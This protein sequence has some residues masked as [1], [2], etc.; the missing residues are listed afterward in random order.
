MHPEDAYTN[1]YDYDVQSQFL[2]EPNR[3]LDA[4]H[5]RLVKE[6]PVYRVSDQSLEKA[7]W[8]LFVDSLD[9]LRDCSAALS[10]KEHR[11]AGRLFRDALET[12]D[13]AEFLATNDAK[14][15]KALTEWYENEVISHRKSRDALQR[16]LGQDVSQQRRQRYRE[17]SKFTHRTYRALLQSYSVGR[18]DR[19]VYDGLRD[20]QIL[21]LP[22]TIAAF[23]TILADRLIEF[24]SKIE[25][26]GILP[27]EVNREIWS[28]SLESHTVP[29]RFV[30]HQ[31]KAT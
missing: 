17:L 21:V 30:P 5:Q 19:L 8:M 16:K 23:L 3:I 6:G 28:Q 11:I 22:Q 25:A 24:S 2:R 27:D 7:L 4:Y 29:R 14:A 9:A 26:L 10:R 20:S 1:P 12:M 13:L 31:W 15:K 18:N